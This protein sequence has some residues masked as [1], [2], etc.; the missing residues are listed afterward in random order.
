MNRGW[1]ELFFKK[2][3]KADKIDE[4]NRKLF[5]QHAMTSMLSKDL[6]LRVDLWMFLMFLRN[7]LKN[8]K[9][10]SRAYEFCI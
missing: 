2:N 9:R 3:L 10:R 7:E 8:E 1:K 5:I 4:K 6:Y